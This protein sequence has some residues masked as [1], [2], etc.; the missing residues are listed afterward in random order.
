[1]TDTETRFATLYRTY[2]RHV[3]AYCLRRTEPHLVDDAVADTFMTAWRKIDAL[4]PDEEALPWLYAVA[5]RVLGR[6]WRSSS[7]RK[8]LEAKLTG[9]GVE[10]VALP[11][12]QFVHA[13]ET[14]QMIRALS[15]L[16]DRDQEI[17]RLAVWEELS[18]SEMGTVLGISADAARQRLSEA[19][20]RLTREY[21]RLE[22]RQISTPAVQKGG[23]A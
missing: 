11:E 16:K 5:Y 7:R 17:L 8:K 12:T 2:S 23:A 20:K 22:E 18:G 3:Y 21:N 1:M 4:P 15:R 10:P 19:R 13:L 14:E 6:Q 9:L